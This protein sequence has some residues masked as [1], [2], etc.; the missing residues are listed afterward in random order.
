MRPAVQAAGGGACILAGIAFVAALPGLNPWVPILLIPFGV[1]LAVGAAMERVQ[2]DEGPPDD[3]RF[4][5]MRTFARS[6][7]WQ[8]SFVVLMLLLLLDFT[9]TIRLNGREV[10]VTLFLFMGIR[11]S[12]I[13]RHLFRKGD[14]G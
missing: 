14:P 13:G 5:K 1:L 2:N 6:Y 4:R 12:A 3:E 8:T 11:A 10:L 7:A 9:G